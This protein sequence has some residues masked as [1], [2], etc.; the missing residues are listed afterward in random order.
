MFEGIGR[1]LLG[2]SLCLGGLNDF[3]FRGNGE[4]FIFLGD[5]AILAFICGRRRI[6][7]TMTG[8]NCTSKLKTLPPFPRK[9][10]S[11]DSCANGANYRFLSSARDKSRTAAAYLKLLL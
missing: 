11:P 2:S 6:C 8:E 4:C 1:F 7:G 9:R 3:R 10:E 5:W